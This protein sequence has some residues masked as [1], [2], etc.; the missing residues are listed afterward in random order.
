MIDARK[1]LY[2]YSAQNITLSLIQLSSDNFSDIE[3]EN[4][5]IFSQIIDTAKCNVLHFHLD[6][7][8]YNKVENILKALIEDNSNYSEL[9]FIPFFGDTSF[10]TEHSKE[11]DEKLK[12]LTETNVLL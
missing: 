7:E 9:L 4:K 5:Y 2:F 11:N 1:D 8:L 10:N 6:K 12:K 3:D